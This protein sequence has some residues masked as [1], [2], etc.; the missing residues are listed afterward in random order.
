MAN[1]GRAGGIPFVLGG[2]YR[3]TRVVQCTMHAFASHNAMT[4]A[5]HKLAAG[6]FLLIVSLVFDR[7]PISAVS[8]ENAAVVVKQPNLDK[9]GKCWM[10]EKS[11]LFPKK[12]L[13]RS[14]Q[15]VQR[16][17]RDFFKWATGNDSARKLFCELQN[18]TALSGDGGVWLA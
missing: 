17:M 8:A 5:N 14:F 15:G 9:R 2:T 10:S 11:K 4:K 7:R 12:M 6:K 13:Y 1:G 18:S 3:M 16:L